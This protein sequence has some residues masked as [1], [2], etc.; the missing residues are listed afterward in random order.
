[1]SQPVRERL[2]SRRRRETRRDIHLAAL[3]LVREQ[4]FD[5]V[6]VDMISAEAGI[7]TRTF[8]NYFPSRDVAFLPGPPEVAD[9]LAAR[10][11]VA[12]P[13]PLAQVLTDLTGLLAD[14]LSDQEPQRQELHDAFELAHEHPQLLAT[15]LA[16]FEVVQVHL[17]ELVAQR[18]SLPPDDE[19]P[20]MI[21]AVALTAVRRGLDRWARTDADEP[22][23][24]YVERS[25]A[26]LHTLL[27]PDAGVTP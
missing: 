20:G 19:V 6:T 18:L 16:Q 5:K 1:M 22:V 14:G 21:A 24:P 9:D 3:R 11:V 2:R 13:A 8:F 23:R 26:L 7:S 17:A 15:M 27:T 10:F 25:T 4:G 12:G